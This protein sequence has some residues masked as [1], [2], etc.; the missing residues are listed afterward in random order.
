MHCSPGFINTCKYIRLHPYTWPGQHG[1]KEAMTPMANPGS[2]CIA[3]AASLPSKALGQ[4]VAPPE[5]RQVWRVTQRGLQPTLHM[6]CLS[7]TQTT[8]GLLI[9]LQGTA[10][11]QNHVL[12]AVAATCE[13]RSAIP[14]PKCKKSSNTTRRRQIGEQAWC[15]GQQLPCL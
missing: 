15:G 4:A 2:S 1:I 14:R 8:A 6:Q 10:Q 9:K 3:W 5:G 13:L 11:P 12:H 7:V